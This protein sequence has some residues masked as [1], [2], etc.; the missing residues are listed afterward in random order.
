MKNQ[1]LVAEL[2]RNKDSVQGRHCYEEVVDVV[3]GSTK[4]KDPKGLLNINK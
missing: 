1:V 2:E 3:E 4:M